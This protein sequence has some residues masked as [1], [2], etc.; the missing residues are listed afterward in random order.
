MTKI[1]G[2]LFCQCQKKVS[3][4]NKTRTLSRM[5]QDPMKHFS[6]IKMHPT[7]PTVEVKKIIPILDKEGGRSA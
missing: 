4:G 6:K 7:P 1:P 3:I 5:F 2:T